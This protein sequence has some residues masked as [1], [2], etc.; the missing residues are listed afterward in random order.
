MGMVILN[1]ETYKFGCLECLYE[2]E[3][4]IPDFL[5]VCPRCKSK[6]VVRITPY[7][8]THY[9]S[10]FLGDIISPKKWWRIKVRRVEE[11]S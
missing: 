6:K 8:S 11:I 9:K 3:I 7:C 10:I 2:W 5:P 4:T 1:M